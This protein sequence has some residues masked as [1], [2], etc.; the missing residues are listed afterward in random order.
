[1]AAG[2]GACTFADNC[3]SAST[4]TF[5]SP[6][7]A[8]NTTCDACGDCDPTIN[9]FTPAGGAPNWGN[10][11]QCDRAWANGG[12]GGTFTDA[13]GECTGTIDCMA[14]IASCSGG[15]SLCG[16]PENTSYSKVC[17]PSTFTGS[18]SFAFAISGIT[19]AGGGASLQYGVYPAGSDAQ[20]GSLATLY[21]AGGGTLFCDGASTTNSTNNA[22]LTPGT[23]HLVFFDGNA[24]A[25]CQWTFNVTP[26]TPTAAF[27]KSATSITCGACVTFTTTGTCYSTAA[28]TTSDGQSSSVKN[29]SFCWATAGTYTITQTL[30]SGIGACALTA[31]TSQTVTVTCGCPVITVSM[32]GTN[33][34]CNGVCTGSATGT[35]SGGTSPYTYK[36]STGQTTQTRSSL[37]AGTYTVTA[38]DANN[39]K[40]FASVTLTQPTPLTISIVGTNLICNSVCNGSATGTGAGGTAAYTYKWST[41]Q[42]TQTRTSLCIGTYTVTAID[43]NLC[44]AFTSVTL[45]QPVAVTVT[46]TSTNLICNGVCVGAAT[47]TGATGVGP[48]TY[49]WASGQV[50]QTI[51]S[52]CAGTYRVTAIDANGCKANTPVTITSP[53]TLTATFTKGVT[54]CTECTCENWALFNVTGGTLPR[55]YKWS[56]GYTNK[57]LNGICSGTFTATSTDANGC[58]AWATITVP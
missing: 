54:S 36:W 12:C 58:K 56:N 33:L 53:P 19:C 25:A 52:L 47:G 38:I 17:V 41:G 15:Y 28:W 55:T 18:C 13:C 49:K 30:S 27:T 29:P 39:C 51:S 1:M 32:V 22:T 23:C 9:T 48:Y 26:P 46:T 8:D 11:D 57:Y 16:S 40:G 42:T 50:T 2:G 4:F 21:P 7:T 31:T 24:E 6:V 5:C 35:G 45:T 20:C 3:G 10:N 44:K 34:L 37:C 43:A 14:A